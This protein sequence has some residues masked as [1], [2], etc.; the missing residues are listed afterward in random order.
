MSCISYSTYSLLRY[1]FV[2]QVFISYKVSKHGNDPIAL[3]FDGHKPPDVQTGTLAKENNVR[4][5]LL[6]V[7]RLNFPS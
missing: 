1:V 4:T 6:L 7:A 3:F 2:F 5:I